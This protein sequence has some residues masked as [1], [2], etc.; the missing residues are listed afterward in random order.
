ML[1]AGSLNQ[2]SCGRDYDCILS[3]G[4]GRPEKYTLDGLKKPTTS[5]RYPI[6][7]L[8]PHTNDRIIAQ[9]GSFTIHGH[10]SIALD[11]L[12]QRRG[13][14]IRLARITIDRANIP[15]LWRELELMGISEASLFPGL[16]SL[17]HVIKWF[18]QLP[19]KPRT[20]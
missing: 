12:A 2:F 16:E 4:G 7:I 6:A 14:S 3:V 9:Q 15:H 19:G 13:S 8:P 1:D 20:K 17:A 5:N 11:E 18:G 10:E